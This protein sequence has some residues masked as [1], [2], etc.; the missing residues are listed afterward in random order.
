[1]S[2]TGGTGGR[3]GGRNVYELILLSILMRVRTHGYVIAAVVNEMVG[4]LASA[5]NAR[6]YPLLAQMAELGFVTVDAE[7]TTEGGR[8]SRSFGVTVAGRARFRELMLDMGSSPRDYRKL[9]AFKMMAFDL[10][11]SEERVRILKH[12][13]AFSRAH[14]RHLDRQ[15]RNFELVWGH[16]YAQGDRPRLSG[17]FQHL[18]RSWNDEAEW[19][20]AILRLE[21]KEDLS[22]VA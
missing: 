14:M 13:I 1:L 22:S 3:V 17:V 11:T 7:Y 2:E 12:Y 8:V 20:T 21:S 4:P 5:S 10:I 16:G 6:I 9:F 15:A 18:A 19:A